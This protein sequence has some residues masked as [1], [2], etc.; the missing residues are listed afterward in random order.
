MARSR[1]GRRELSPTEKRIV[2]GIIVLIIGLTITLIILTLNT[3]SQSVI[4]ALPPYNGE[5]SDAL[6]DIASKSLAVNGSV[7]NDTIRYLFL[8]EYLKLYNGSLLFNKTFNVKV[9]LSVAY[10]F[11]ATRNETIIIKTH[12]NGSYYYALFYTENRYLLENS[13]TPGNSSRIFRIDLPDNYF[14]PGKPYM[15]FTVIISSNSTRRVTGY[16]TVSKKPPIVLDTIIRRAPIAYYTLMLDSWIRDRYTVRDEPIS[17][18]LTSTRSVGE[19]LEQNGTVI[20]SLEASLIAKTLLDHVMVESHIVAVDTN[21]DGVVDHFAVLFKYPVKPGGVTEY[22]S[23]LLN[24]LEGFNL[25]SKLGDNEALHVKYI[26]Y[27][28]YSWIVFDPVYSNGVPGVVITDT[29]HVL[30]MII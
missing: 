17:K 5:Y 16:V 2:Y 11:Y 28:D 22:S 20:N 21:N 19:L 1:K 29:Y 15:E 24:I 23:R 26:Y 3:P 6:R 12:G 18:V 30:G 13:E 14:P 8:K 25:A 4:Y 9:N 10:V 7:V 27:G